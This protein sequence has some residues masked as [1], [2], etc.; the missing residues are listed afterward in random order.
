MKE[1]HGWVVG[2]F[3]MSVEGNRV[4]IVVGCSSHCDDEGAHCYDSLMIC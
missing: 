2:G 3:Q 1:N 4:V